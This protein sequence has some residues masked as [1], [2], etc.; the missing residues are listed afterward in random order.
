M[1]RIPVS[2]SEVIRSGLCIGCGNCVAQAGSSLVRMDFDKYGQLKPTGSPDWLLSPSVSFSQICPF[3]P[4]AK[5]EDELAE[6]LFRNAENHDSRIGRFQKAYVG[7]VEEGDFRAKGSS[8]GLVTWVLSE[9]LQRDLIDGV[10]H[11]VPVENPYQTGRFFEYR[12]SRTIEE[13]RSGAQSRYYPIEMSKVLQTAR[14]VPGRYAFVGIPCFIKAVHLL[15]KE[16]PILKERIKFTL[17]LFCGHMKTARFVESLAWQMG[18]NIDE[19]QSIDFRHKTPNR[20]ANWYRAKLMLRNGRILEKDWWDL[21]D[22]DWGAGYFMNSACNACDDVVAET[23]DISFGDAWVKPYAEDPWGTNV[24]ITRS[25]LVE[26]LVNNGIAQGRLKLKEVDSEFVS[27]TQ[28]AALR[29]RREGLAYRLVW[30]RSALKLQKRVN[31]DS[32]QL[33]RWRKL[34]YRMRFQISLWSHRVFWLSRHLKCPKLYIEWA[35]IMLK[36]YHGLAYQR[37][38]VGSIMVRFGLKNRMVGKG[39]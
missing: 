36:I 32:K 34:I 6:D 9:L 29:Q 14:E 27:K 33:T 26:A 21:A 11:V 8:G 12:I 31:P 39:T 7:H 3:S 20:P 15:R 35:R 5:N 24:I 2:P 4:L 25:P 1:N 30:M 23:A 19:V 17:G 18:I 10:A 28:A 22:G 38:A 13:I 37:G 16:D